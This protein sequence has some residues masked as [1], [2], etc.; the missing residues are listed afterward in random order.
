M[1]NIA[2]IIMC[3][4]M[5]GCAIPQYDAGS[6]EIDYARLYSIAAKLIVND[7]QHNLEGLAE[8][9]IDT[10]E[11]LK[12]YEATKL[13]LEAARAIR[14]GNQARNIRAARVVVCYLSSQN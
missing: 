5:Q 10:E 6:A 9:G 14:D 1:K 7:R 4:Y 12:W 8:L 2:I 3:L 11:F 13:A